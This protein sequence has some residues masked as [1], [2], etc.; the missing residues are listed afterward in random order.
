[1]ILADVYVQGILNVYGSNVNRIELNYL[2]DILDYP[3]AL[4][5][6]C[7]GLFCHSLLVY[8]LT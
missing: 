7:I 2:L 5:E 3:Q 8:L 4:A 6:L 1:M